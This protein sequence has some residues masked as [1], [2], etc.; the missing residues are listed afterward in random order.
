[1][2]SRSNPT[3]KQNLPVTHGSANTDESVKEDGWKLR[4]Q[5]IDGSNTF[6]TARHSDEN[7]RLWTYLLNNLPTRSEWQ[8]IVWKRKEKPMQ[9]IAPAKKAEKTAFSCHWIS[10][11][12]R[13]KK[14]TATPMNAMHPEIQFTGHFIFDPSQMQ[15]SL[16]SH[17]RERCSAKQSFGK[18]RAPLSLCEHS[19]N[20]TRTSLFCEC[21]L[22]FTFQYKRECT[23]PEDASRCCRSR[24]EFWISIWS[25]R[26]PS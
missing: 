5:N 19:L 17:Q 8:Y 22:Q 26:G 10:I 25:R 18:E 9:R 7:P 15:E 12:G 4:G 20:T 6:N 2:R 16:D 3:C 23:N 24:C 11:D 21:C 1:M 13:V 14:Y